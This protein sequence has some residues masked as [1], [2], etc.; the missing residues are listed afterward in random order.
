M[1]TMDENYIYG[2]FYNGKL[3][4]NLLY[5]DYDTAVKIKEQMMEEKFKYL[6]QL[7]DINGLEYVIKLD[8]NCIAAYEEFNTTMYTYDIRKLKVN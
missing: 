1:M 6:N 4:E 7:L 5:K 8:D 2:I 3:N